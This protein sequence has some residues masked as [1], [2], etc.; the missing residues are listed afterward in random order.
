M[1]QSFSAIVVFSFFPPLCNNRI[2]SYH[3][4]QLENEGKQ[5]RNIRTV[6]YLKAYFH[7]E[8]EAGK[9]YLAGGGK[10]NTTV[11]RCICIDHQLYCVEKGFERSSKGE[12]LRR[13]CWKKKSCCRNH[14][15]TIETN[16]RSVRTILPPLSDNGPHLNKSSFFFI[17]VALQLLLMQK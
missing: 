6:R 12:I 16:T 2:L 11:H 13:R 7:H 15:S 8:G 9:H 14:G 4:Q 5:T 1:R 3:R 10:R 17:L